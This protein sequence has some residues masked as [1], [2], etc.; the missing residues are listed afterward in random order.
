MH[1]LIVAIQ[2]SFSNRHVAYEIWVGGPASRLGVL[3]TEESRA[4]EIWILAFSSLWT[5]IFLYL[6]LNLQVK[7]QSS[8]TFHL[9]RSCTWEGVRKMQVVNVCIAQRKMV[10]IFQL[11]CEFPSEWLSFKTFLFP[12]QIHSVTIKSVNGHV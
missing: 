5:I 2:S 1:C 6:F 12:Y 4:F 10:I 11:S 3:G 9:P 7:N 8:L